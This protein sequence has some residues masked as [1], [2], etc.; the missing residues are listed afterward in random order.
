MNL[1]VENI[2]KR[3]G[4]TLANSG[5]SF[6]VK[7]GEVL[8]ILGENG[9]GKTTLMRVIYGMEKPN[10]GQVLI[11]GQ[12]VS[13][14]SPKDAIGKGIGMVHQHFMLVNNFTVTE[15]LIL[16]MKEFTGFSLKKEKIE[17]EILEYLGK[18]KFQLNPSDI[19]K[20]LPVGVQQRIEILKALFKGAELLI[21]DE[22]TS[23]LTPQETAELA[24]IIKALS[25]EGKSV[26]LISHKLDEVMQMCSRCLIL[27][28]GKLV[29]DV[30]T[31]DTNPKELAKMMI[32]TDLV[33]PEKKMLDLPQRKKML[34]IKNFTIE[35]KGVAKNKDISL[36]VWN[37]EIV[38]VAGVDGNGQTELVEAVAGLRKASKG[39]VLVDGQSIF[40]RHAGQVRA[41]GLSHIPE[42]RHK[43]GLVLSFSVENNLILDD[44][45]SDKFC[46]N[47]VMNFKQVSKNGKKYVQEYQI[48]TESEKS[49]ASSL[50][51]GNQQKIVVAREISV[52]PKV[53]VAM[54]P[55]RGLDIGA[56]DYIHRCLLEERAN[57]KAILLVSTE[58]D[59]ILTL[60]DRIA[61]MHEGKLTG[62]V[63]PEEVSPEDIG[64]MMA[65]S[66]TQF[67]ALKPK[68][69]MEED[70]LEH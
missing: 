52:N 69:G 35:E 60:A 42:D 23:V 4:N 34:E 31:A 63:W 55:T 46:K 20:N 28:S 38:G 70:D 24:V 21:L 36:D 12:A 51:G 8:A 17:K 61:V 33:K 2:T 9:A 68:D 44:F 22:P 66:K 65:G 49:P 53:L 7:K 62:L 40:N 43:R 11:D 18:Y 39:E 50:S 67:T 54:K 30:K 16:G 29:G 64:E 6:S 41:K 27:R 5:I 58:L 19:V 32:G 48:K 1:T 14:R 10:M 37:G 3:Y 57:G 56:V 13:F 26:I 59:E 47:H 45:Y 15:N 25:E